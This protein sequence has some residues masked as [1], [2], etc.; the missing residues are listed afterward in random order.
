MILWSRNKEAKEARQ[1]KSDRA[2]LV[3]ESTTEVIQADMIIRKAGFHAKVMGPPPEIQTGCD[4]VLEIQIDQELEIQRL[5][6]KNNIEPMEY[7]TVDGPLLQPVEL[8]KVKDFGEYLMVRAANMKVTINKSTL[9]IVNVSG[10]GCPDVP[11]LASL[12][13]GQNLLAA[14]KPV[15]HGSTLCGYALQMAVEELVRICSR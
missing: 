9:E 15:E 1:N 8:F 6:R 11:Y 4:M 12:I 5:L 7:M 10:G 13:V 2:I 3:F 14:P